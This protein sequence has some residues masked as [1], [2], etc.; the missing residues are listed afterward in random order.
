[1]SMLRVMPHRVQV[2]SRYMSRC[3]SAMQKGE[4]RPMSS[5]SDQFFE[6]EDELLAE[7]AQRRRQRRSSAP[8]ARP[9]RAGPLRAAPRSRARP[10]GDASPRRLRWRVAIAV[11]A[12]ILGFAL[13]Y[14]VALNTMGERIATTT[15]RCSS[16][17][18]A[19]APRRRSPP[20]ARPTHLTRDRSTNRPGLP[21]GH[22]DLS[23]FINR[24]RHVQRRG[25]R[26]V[27]RADGGRPGLL[28]ER[29]SSSGRVSYTWL[30]TRTTPRRSSRS[31]S[32]S[33]P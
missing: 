24:G 10:A 5:G 2:R 28:V 9:P 21:E 32:S 6:E 26:G 16:T 25:D 11:V 27:S 3:T 14:F 7:Q 22:P 29:C 13:G 8:R 33:S 30:L 23:Q 15:A 18:R 19:A 31:S 4:T 12:L 17:P 1:M 20:P